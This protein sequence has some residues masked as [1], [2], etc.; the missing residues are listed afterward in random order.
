VKNKWGKTARLYAQMYNR[1]DI[2]ARE[3]AEEAEAAAAC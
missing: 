2:A 1:A 3:E